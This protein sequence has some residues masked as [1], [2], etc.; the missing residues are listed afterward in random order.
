MNAPVPQHKAMRISKEP[1]ATLLTPERHAL[2]LIARLTSIAVL[3]AG[4]VGCS[5]RDLDQYSVETPFGQFPDSGSNDADTSVIDSPNDWAGDESAVVEHSGDVPQEPWVD[6][7]AAADRPLADTPTDPVIADTPI[8][9]VPNDGPPCSKDC[10][11]GACVG[12]ECQPV[13]FAAGQATPQ[14]VV[15]VDGTVVWTDFAGLTPYEGSL[16]TCPVAG[17]GAGPTTL[18]IFLS[19]PWALAVRSKIAYWTNYG[20]GMITSCSITNCPSVSTL[21]NGQSVPIGI[22]VD[23]TYVYWTNQ[24]G[25]TVMRTPLTADAGTSAT[26]IADSSAPWGIL[27]DATSIYW[28]SGGSGTLSKANKDGTN[29][30][31]LTP[32]QSGQQ[33]GIAMD[34]TTIFW[35]I[36][37]D[38]AGRILRVNKDGNS[39]AVVASSLR[40]PWGVALDANDV[41]WTN[42]SDG[43]V[44]KCP[45]SNCSQPTTI[46]TG[47]QR[48]RGI[49][50]SQNAVFWASFSA[51][52]DGSIMML[53]K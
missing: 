46:A 47:Q 23:D 41:Y 1:P 8:E 20:S 43:T 44:M 12:G 21:A 11:G 39:A 6:V 29:P 16:K 35:A 32:A 10:L 26:K 17:C 4:S 9:V 7:E 49:A 34:N 37:E 42:E 14:D 51:G 38:Y 53:A 40:A 25:N 33:I 36:H 50:L 30:S 31:V 3:A 13:A 15:V 5:L 27:V 19:G 28:L 22:A 52:T 24:L 48:P 18:A 45:K 2:V